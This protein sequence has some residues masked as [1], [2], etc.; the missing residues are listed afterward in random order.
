MR[1][2]LCRATTGVAL[3]AQHVGRLSIVVQG[4]LQTSAAATT[5]QRPVGASISWRSSGLL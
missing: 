2:Q 4:S 1:R 5:E 3:V